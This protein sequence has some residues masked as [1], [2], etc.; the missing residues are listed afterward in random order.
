MVIATHVSSS[1]LVGN[2][3]NSYAEFSPRW[4]LA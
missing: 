2:Y 3:L 4:L 1:V